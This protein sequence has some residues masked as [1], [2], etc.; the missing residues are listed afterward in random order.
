MIDA[1]IDY[2]KSNGEWYMSNLFLFCY[3]MLLFVIYYIFLIKFCSGSSCS[4]KRYCTNKQFQNK[5]FKKT[6]IIKTEKKGYGICAVEDIPKYI[7][8]TI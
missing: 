3:Y 7:N 6:N 8:F 2:L 1:L 5:Q 4:L